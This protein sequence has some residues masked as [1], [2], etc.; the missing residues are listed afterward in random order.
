MSCCLCGRGN[1]Q[2]C[3][4]TLPNPPPQLSREFPCSPGTHSASQY[5]ICP[6][7]VSAG[8]KGLCHHRL[9]LS[10]ALLLL[11]LFRAGRERRSQFLE[12]DDTWVSPPCSVQ[13]GV[14]R[15]LWNPLSAVTASFGNWS[16][17]PGS[18][19]HSDRFPHFLPFV[20]PLSVP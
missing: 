3:N 17:R 20:T 4:L 6:C 13:K 14:W 15:L 7:F 16:W 18:T 10:V 2:A 19:L 1:R 9:L 11:L 5:S 8:T 12:W